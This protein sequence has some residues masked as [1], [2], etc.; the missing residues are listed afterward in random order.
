MV[1]ELE[2]L[3]LSA[4]SRRLPRALRQDGWPLCLER[5]QGSANSGRSAAKLV[6]PDTLRAQ[7]RAA[8]S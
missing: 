3:R 2:S 8:G 5:R 7:V 1:A 6:T 4:R